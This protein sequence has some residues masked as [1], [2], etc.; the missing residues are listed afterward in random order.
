M[1][2]QFGISNNGNNCTEHSDSYGDNEESLASFVEYDSDSSQR[3]SKGDIFF[4]GDEN[5]VSEN[6]SNQTSKLHPVEPI[7]EDMHGI[8]TNNCPCKSSYEPSNSCASYPV[9]T[10]D[11]GERLVVVPYPEFVDVME[12]N[13]HV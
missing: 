10:I 12:R 7:Q 11:D 6:N 4:T 9:Y 1:R 8:S 3:I 13:L 2:D 5:P